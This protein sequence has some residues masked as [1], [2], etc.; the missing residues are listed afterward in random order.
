MYAPHLGSVHSNSLRKKRK[1][2]KVFMLSKLKDYLLMPKDCQLEFRQK[3]VETNRF[4]MRLGCIILC[5]V[6]PYTMWRVLFWTSA[7]LSTLNNRIYFTMYTVLLALAVIWLLLDRPLRKTSL[8][9]QYRTQFF[10]ILLMM[11]WTVLL[12]SYDLYRDADARVLVFH[13]FL[14]LFASFI[15]LSGWQTFA[16]LGVSYLA[17]E[18]LAHPWITNGERA[19]LMISLGLAIGIGFANTHHIVV[20]IRQKREIQQMNEQLQWMVERDPL[21]DMLNQ[22]AIC[23]RTRQRLQNLKP[24]EKVTLLI[25]DLDNFKSVNDQFGHPCGDYVLTAVGHCL[26]SVFSDSVGIGRIGGDEFVV[27]FETALPEAE[28]AARTA[29]LVQEVS[30]IRW[31]GQD[32]G[33]CCSVGVC[34][35][36]GTEVDYDRLYQEADRVLYQAKRA[37]KGCCC[38]EIS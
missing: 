27:F 36:V 7:G 38:V 4:L 23:A 37:G 12:S 24:G 16:T 6:E 15:R 2:C 29:R 9:V 33:I 1:D 3:C 35:A 26:R 5:L 25:L 19:N 31:N 18:L 34:V 14:L 17:F 22:R 11:G 13:S 8:T 21:T 20:W 28:A 30:A 32:L 10:G